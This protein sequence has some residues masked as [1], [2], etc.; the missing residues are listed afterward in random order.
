MFSGESMARIG[1]SADKVNDK[2]NFGQY[3]L[4]RF[5]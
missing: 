2:I 4:R 5:K 3:M 1:L